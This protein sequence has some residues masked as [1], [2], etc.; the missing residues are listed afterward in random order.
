MIYIEYGMMMIITSRNDRLM[1]EKISEIWLNDSFFFLCEMNRMSCDLIKW[2]NYCDRRIVRFDSIC[3]RHN[4]CKEFGIVLRW[5]A[6]IWKLTLKID[7]R[8]TQSE[9]F[10]I[11]LMSVINEFKLRTSQIAIH[12]WLQT[13][14]W[15]AIAF[16]IQLIALICCFDSTKDIKSRKQMQRHWLFWFS[17]RPVICPL[18]WYL[19]NGTRRLSIANISLEH[20]W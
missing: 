19:Q 9:Q 4:G 11:S 7:K 17:L 15:C 3:F 20:E 14:I 8:R 2:I 1:T 18:F 6:T 5:C 13:D 12:F 16:S 10:Q